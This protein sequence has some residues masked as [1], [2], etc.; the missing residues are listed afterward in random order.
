MLDV[1]SLDPIGVCQLGL[2]NRGVGR[3]RLL[4]HGRGAQRAQRSQADGCKQRDGRRD[5]AACGVRRSMRP[6]FHD[7]SF[8]MAVQRD[9]LAVHSCSR[10]LNALSE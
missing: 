7:G 4:G 5:A 2:F 8:L 6:R 1:G 9:S 3:V 10:K